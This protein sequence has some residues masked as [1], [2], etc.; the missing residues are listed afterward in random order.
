VR[1]DALPPPPE[2][3]PVHTSGP[4]TLPRDECLSLLRGNSVGRLAFVV[5]GWPVVL[6]VNYLVDGEDIV[7]RTDPG[8]KLSSVQSDAQVSFQVDAADRL[9]RSGWSVLVYGVASEINDDQEIEHLRGAL[10]SWAG[11]AKDY[12][13]RVQAVQ[14]SGRRLPKGWQYPHSTR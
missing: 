6:P 1:A 11:G 4:A 5:D 8:T 13:I 9:F 10:R 14:I 3:R 7:L 2:D 12:W